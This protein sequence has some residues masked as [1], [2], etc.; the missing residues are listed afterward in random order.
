MSNHETNIE[1]DNPLSSAKIGAYSGSI[2]AKFYK[3]GKVFKGIP[4]VDIHSELRSVLCN[5]KIKIQPYN[6]SYKHGQLQIDLPNNI[7]GSL[8]N[9]I[10][11]KT[12]TTV[13]L[14]YKCIS[15]KLELDN[16]TKTICFHY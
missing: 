14:R 11:V 16:I 1:L 15:C 9:L 4:A 13:G 10:I 6:V 12:L 3:S 2:K 5:S 7:K 8:A